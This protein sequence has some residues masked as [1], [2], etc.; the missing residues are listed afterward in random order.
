[1]RLSCPVSELRAGETATAEVDATGC[2]LLDVLPGDRRT[3]AVSRYRVTLAN[4][5][6]LRVNATSPDF[7]PA[8]LVLDSDNREQGRDARTLSTAEIAVPLQPGA[9]T[10]AV[11]PAGG[12][13]GRFT[14]ETSLR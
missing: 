10:I 3:G 13:G 14:I 4:A 1:M 8:I 5:A 9:Y 12:E 11:T 6:T 7:M 2:R